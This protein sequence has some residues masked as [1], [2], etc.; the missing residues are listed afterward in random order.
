[1]KF[2]RCVHQGITMYGL[3]EQDAIRIISGDIFSTYTVTAATVASAEAVILPPCVPSKIIAVGL[4]YRSHAAEMNMALPDE[5]LLFL[6]P[7]TAVIGHGDAIVYPA[8]AQRVDYEGELGVVIGKTCRHVAAAEAARY[9][10]GYTCFNDVTARDLQKKDGQFT[11]AKGFDTF[12]PV[13][14]CIATDLAPDNL[15][16]ATFLNGRQRQHGTTSDLIFPVYHLVAFISRIMTLLPGDL[17]ATGTP[18]GIGPMQAGDRIE[19]R[20]EGIGTLKNTV[21]EAAGTA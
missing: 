3:L 8:M 13:G 2:V 12:A 17:I 16:I 11:R 21:A 15:A 19:V 10:L 9:I 5:P 14:P 18:S 4:N 20:I 1:M 6:K 7:A